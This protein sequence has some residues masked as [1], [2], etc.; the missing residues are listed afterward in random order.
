MQKGINYNLLERRCCSKIFVT[1]IF[2][3][4]F[5]IIHF[6]KLY[7]FVSYNNLIFLL[8]VINFLCLN[9]K[10]IKVRRN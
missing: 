3:E 8:Y 1:L 6:T 4:L 2:L 5:D 9:K 10:I 7:N